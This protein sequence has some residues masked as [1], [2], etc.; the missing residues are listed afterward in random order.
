MNQTLQELLDQIEADE[1]REERGLRRYRNLL[2]AHPH[3]AD[4]KH[5]GC[6]QCIDLDEDEDDAEDEGDDS[7]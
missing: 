4:E 6:S 1:I 3:C 5:P 7:L 2:E